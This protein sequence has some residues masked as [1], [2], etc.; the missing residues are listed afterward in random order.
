MK[1]FRHNQCWTP[2]AIEHNYETL[3]TEL[4]DR[5]AVYKK[6]GNDF[7][8]T[9]LTSIKLDPGGMYN[10]RIPH[11]Q[12][13]L[14]E[15]IFDIQLSKIEEVLLCMN[16]ADASIKGYKLIPNWN[17]FIL[18]QDSTY[19]A[20]KGFLGVIEKSDDAL[21]AE[22]EDKLVRDQLKSEGGFL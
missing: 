4:C 14:N 15:V 9:I 16:A 20:L 17:Y 2:V 13:T 18:L 19:E 21:H 7:S 22:L 11:K 1:L 8:E 12:F 10:T 6:Y 3:L 5:I